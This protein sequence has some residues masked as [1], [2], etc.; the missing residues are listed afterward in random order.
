MALPVYRR[1]GIMY[2][3]LPRVETANLKESARSFETIN[4]R[5]DQLSSFVSKKG[6]EYAQEQAMQYAAQN[7]VTEQQIAEAVASKGE[8]QSW[9]SAL[10]GGNVYDETLAAAQGSMLAN[11]LSIEAQKKFRQ[12]Q[13]MAENNQIGFDEAQLE[14]Q[15]V[16]DGYAATI[17][18]FSPEASIKARA[19]MATAGNGVLKSVAE[20]QS[21]IFAAAQA[22]K[23]D[24][25][26]MTVRRFAEDEFAR[27]DSWNPT[28][29]TYIRAEDRIAAIFNPIEEQALAMGQ[30][31]RF[32]KL[33]EA[34]REAR[35]N[36]V[37]QGLLDERFAAS[38][39][40]A[41]QKVVNGQLG[42][43]ESS[44][45]VMTDDDRDK[46]KQKMMKEIADRR[47]IKDK[48]EKDLIDDYKDQAVN[49]Q[50]E[51]FT[52]SRDRQ[53]EIATELMTINSD[54]G[55]LITPV[56]FITKLSEGKLAEKIDNGRLM[57]QLRDSV[58]DGVLNNDSIEY[59]ASNE[60]IT[61]DQAKELQNRI[62]KNE[63]AEIKQALRLGKAEVDKLDLPSQQKTQAKASLTSDIL[64]ASDDPTIDLNQL[65]AA[66]V[67][68]QEES[69][70]NKKAKM[71]VDRVASSLSKS[72]IFSGDDEDQIQKRTDMAKQ[73]IENIT[74]LDQ[75]EGLPDNV[76]A[77]IK[78]YLR[79]QGYSAR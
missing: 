9:L 38:P 22:A 8:G 35:V 72:I 37:T 50:M 42:E 4:R 5:L 33:L 3:D 27:G 23:L 1:Q 36:G 79:R 61:W 76:K 48:L 39:L 64:K 2:A 60:Q 75:I 14:I 77:S 21:K 17:S 58:D 66:K 71:V 46:V 26:M 11:Q 70:A 18:A 52:A 59:L 31:D 34:K 53:R 41:Y 12:L 65:V 25:D 78:D 49:L 74:L 7:P 68:E 47:S 56:P 57:F 30:E 44:W 73:I 19:S 40:K 67:K 28:T 55:E 62:S 54:A 20:K 13:V 24:E 16:I 29:Q 69:I 6:T 15:D 45:A 10:T 51:S 63:N 43:Y 32:P